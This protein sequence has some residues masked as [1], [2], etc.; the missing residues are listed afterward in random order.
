LAISASDIPKIEAFSQT[1]SRPVNS[2]LKPAPNSSKAAIRPVYLA[3]LA[4]LGFLSIHWLILPVVLFPFL[5][6]CCSLSLL[7][8]SL[9]VFLRDLGPIIGLFVTGLM[10]LTPIFYP[11]SSVS[12]KVEFWLGLNPMTP[13]VES[14]RAILFSTHWPS[15]A[16]LIYIWLTSLGLLLFSVW[17][18]RRLKTGFADVL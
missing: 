8:A 18:Y 7:F 10:F 9:G 17:V 6:A 3:L 11:L 15:W 12:G 4:S 16:N 2:G 5:L 14:F 13:L 1:F